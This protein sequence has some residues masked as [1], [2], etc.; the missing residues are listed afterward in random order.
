MQIVVLYQHIVL[1]VQD[2]PKSLAT[3]EATAP[4]LNSIFLYRAPAPAIESFMDFWNLIYAKMDTS[5]RR[6]DWS[7]P[8]LPRRR[9]YLTCGG[10][11]ERR[12]QCSFPCFSRFSFRYF[13]TPHT[14]I[15]LVLYSA[16]CCCSPRSIGPRTIA[17]KASKVFGSFPIIP[18]TPP[19]QLNHRRMSSSVRRTLCR[20]SNSVKHLPSGGVS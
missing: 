12:H 11:N 14:C 13:V 17:P 2:L 4:I 20:L 6:L 9:W 19:L 8:A 10:K 15:S 1:K 16:Y 3:L 7:Y 18:S 5:D